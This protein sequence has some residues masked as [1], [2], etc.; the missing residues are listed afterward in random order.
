MKGY[1]IF[2]A[3][4][5]CIGDDYSTKY[6]GSDIFE[7]KVIPKA[8]KQG[9]HFC[10]NIADCFKDEYPLTSETKVVEVA[11]LGDIDTDGIIFCTNRLQ[12]VRELSRYE[13]LDVL[14]SGECN[15]G[16]FNTGTFNTGH[17]LRNPLF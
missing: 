14:R 13:V 1:K 8:G 16:T 10:K 17:F 11:A 3:D 15:T 7:E 2:S 4:W 6:I 9:I 12:V 5:S